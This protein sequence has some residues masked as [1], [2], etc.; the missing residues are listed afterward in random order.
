[1]SQADHG[2][3]QRS[4]GKEVM[5][6]DDVSSDLEWADLRGAAGW[7]RSPAM[8]AAKSGGTGTGGATFPLDAWLASLATVT[9]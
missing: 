5:R 3:A 8:H 1:M 7:L 4:P 2:F 6:L 9:Q